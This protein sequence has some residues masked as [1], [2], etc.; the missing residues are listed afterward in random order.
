MTKRFYWKG[1]NQTVESSNV[2]AFMREN[3]IKDFDSLVKRSQHNIAWFWEAVNDFLGIEWFTPYKKIL[4][5]QKGIEW[6]RWFSGGRINITHN[7]VD[8]HTNTFRRHKTAIIWEGEDGQVRQMTYLDLY[9]QVSRVAQGLR[10]FGIK[11]GD[12]VA[13]FMPMLPETAVGLLAIAKIGAIFTPVFSGYGPE[14]IASRLNDASAKVLF[15][16]DGFY[17]K[18]TIVDMK[19]TADAAVAI[20]P[21]VQH[22]VV[23]KRLG[24]DIPW[25][26]GRDISWD[27]FIKDKPPVSPTEK[28]SSETPWMVIYTSGTTGRPKGAVHVHA[29][30]LIKQAEEVAFQTDLKDQDILFWVTDMGWIMGPW[31]VV[32]GLAM[33]GTLFFYEGA[34]DWPKPDRL[35]EMV[36]AHRISILGISPTAVRALMRSGDQWP[37]S[38]DLSSLR[39]FGSTG[40]PW[41][42]DPWMWLYRQVGKERCPIINL[43]GG[44]EVGACFLSVHPVKPLKPC[45]LGG[46][47][48]GMDI[49]VFDDNAKPVRNAVGELVCKKPWPSMTRGV[50]KDPQRYV[51]TYWSRWEHTWVHG[52]WASVDKDGY[53]FL[54]GRSDDTIKIAGKRV[55]PAEVE[56]VLV[57]HRAVTEAAAI[58]VPDELKGEVLVCFAVLK[59]GYGPSDA[60]RQNLIG[61]VASALGK[62]TTP[63]TVKFVTELP[64]TRN[65][66]I[67][68][69]FIKAKYLGK[70]IADTSSI[71]NLSSLDVI[72]R[73]M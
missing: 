39:M 49:D 51:E 63:K 57:S 6:P 45:S 16:V 71:E 1:F 27:S 36:E 22:V 9:Q 40:E 73:A 67:L 69:R 33:G 28:L 60:L 20:S 12:A 31:E 15:T 23:F 19:K 21:S 66:K 30:F 38:H 11:K 17:R 44:T 29:G 61:L 72:E 52:D 59:P 42:P 24:V 48:L 55:G 37:G 47:A 65:A 25:S 46:P 58:G 8:R 13:V 5:T 26:E 3:R 35:W 10:D 53:W 2:T 62:S 68:R 54:H 4:D 64:R 70:E 43:S 14:A 34:P 56:S 32:G 18:G 50:W 41:N 7:C